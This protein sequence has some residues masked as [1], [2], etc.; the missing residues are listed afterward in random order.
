LPHAL[1]Q[2]MQQ[3]PKVVNAGCAI[4]GDD[5]QRHDLGFVR[6]IQLADDVVLVAEVIVEVARAD[7][8]LVGN[9]RRRNVRFTETIEQREARLEDALACAARP[10]LLRHGNVL[11]LEVR[12]SV[13]RG[14]TRT[15][16][17][18]LARD[19]EP[20]LELVERVA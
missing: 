2:Q 20:A 5:E 11:T 13:V 7:V 6:C 4:G 18:R 8:Q 1:E 16:S 14:R 10:F 12:P 15:Q 9:V 3:Q 17:N 19:G